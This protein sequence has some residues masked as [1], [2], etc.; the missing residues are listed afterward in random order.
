MSIESISVKID[1]YTKTEFQTGGCYALAQLISIITGWTLFV[2]VEKNSNN[3][4]IIHAFCVNDDGFAVDINGIH[5]EDYAKT[6]FSDY[7]IGN[8]IKYQNDEHF[9]YY[10]EWAYEIIC[11][12][13]KYFGIK[14]F[15][16]K[17]VKNKLKEINNQSDYKIN[18]NLIKKLKK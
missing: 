13:F 6:D 3:L 2:E 5:S 15:N 12:N 8:I 11:L 1:D 17:K 18:I 9:G 7:K 10:S 14:D 4:S 16:I